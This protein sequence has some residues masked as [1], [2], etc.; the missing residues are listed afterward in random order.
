ML[1]K[2]LGCFPYKKI[3][4]PK[5]SDLQKKRRRLSSQTG[6]RI[7]TPQNGFFSDE[8]YSDFDDVYN[9]QNDRVWTISRA[10]AEQK[11]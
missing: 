9:V 10:E 11:V 5:L 8:K 3:K 6:F 4:Q 2:D 1:L 7:I